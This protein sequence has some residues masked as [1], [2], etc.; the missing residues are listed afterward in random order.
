MK[1]AIYPI[2]GMHCASCKALIERMVRKLEGVSEVI[3]NFATEKMSVTYDDTKVSEEDLQRAVASAGTYQLVTR[4]GTTVLASPPEAKQ[5]T[6]DNHDLA[7]EL[8]ADEY[9]KLRETVFWVGGATIP[10]VIMMIWELLARTGVAPDLMM[11]LD[12]GNFRLDAWGVEW[13]LLNVVQFILATPVVFLGGKSFF[14]S[15][16]AGLRVRATNM[17]TLIALGTFTAWAFSTVTTFLPDLFRGVGGGMATFFEAAVFITFFILLGRLLEARAKGSASAAIKRLLHLQAKEA[18]V[19]R[20]GKELTVPVDQVMVGDRIMVK[21]GEKLPVD[22]TIEEGESSIDESM[23]TGESLPVEKG[24]GAAVIGATINKTG[25]FVYRASNVGADTLLSQIVR[26]VEEAQTSQAPIQKLADSVSAVFVP[27]V[28][29]LALSAFAFWFFLAPSLGLVPADTDAFRL[30]VYI[31]TTILIIACPCALGL[32]TPV[33]VMVGTGAA[34]AR[35]ILVK[36]AEALDRAHTVDTVVFDKTGTLTKGTPE[37]VG[38]FRDPAAPMDDARLLGLARAIEAKSEH[39][40]SRAIV[41]FADYQEAESVSMVTRF[42]ALEGKGVEGM[43][44]GTIVLLGNERLIKERTITV[45]HAIKDA[46]TAMYRSG[47]TVVF[48][49]IGD[50]VR[51]LFALADTL[52]DDARDAVAHLKRLKIR[53]VMLTGDNR[54]TATAIARL[55]GVDEAIAE[56][57]PGGK[58][59]K[60]AALQDEKG[61]RRIVAMVGDGINDAPALAQADIGIA[62]GTGTDVA[63][64]SADIVLVKGT[65]DKVAETLDLSRRTLTIIKQNLAWAFGYNI[66]AIPIAAGLLYPGTGL[67]LSPIVASAAMAFSSVSVILNSLRLARTRY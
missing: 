35:G 34:A 49:V 37:V 48:M 31:A 30:A 4:D 25:S 5:I 52:K 63:I 66:I 14:R 24:P 16:W 55:A 62:M 3:V 12:S 58:L 53:T 27:V 9:A 32:A 47:S 60:I 54:K 28:I 45:P 19:L 50:T 42:K 29:A 23:V 1:Q 11:V 51:A 22:G 59:R 7:A 40:L 21:P 10:F 8:K 44:D 17:D 38:F 18:R 56:V 13:H 65:L 43:A 39:P 36:N 57:L 2:V 33:A 67:L 46:A 6:E 41:L 15:A 20:D 64:E 26:M 61:K